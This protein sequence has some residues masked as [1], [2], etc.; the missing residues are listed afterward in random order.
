MK[1]EHGSS[2]IAAIVGGLVF[3]FPHLPNVYS[4][5]VAT[6]RSGYR[7]DWDGFRF[8]AK[9]T[10]SVFVG[11]VRANLSEF[12]AYV[13][14][15]G[16]PFLTPT[17]SL[18]LVSIQPYEP[19][20]HPTADEIKEAYSRLPEKARFQMLRMDGHNL[21]QDNWKKNKKGLRLYDYGD[22]GSKTLR[23]SKWIIQNHK[24][25]SKVFSAPPV[26]PA[27]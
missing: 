8:N 2:R 4:W 22:I 3:K 13:L 23:M 7:G 16:A 10:L 11:G 20:E 27:P 9:A 1:I 25:M 17:F 19:G 14:T 12:K 6:V 26:P 24:E 21:Y 18:G 15:L 5:L